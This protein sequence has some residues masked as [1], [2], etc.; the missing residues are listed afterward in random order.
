[1]KSCAS[2][3]SLATV[4][5]LAQSLI[6]NGE[7]ELISCASRLAASDC[8]LNWRRTRMI[9]LERDANEDRSAKCESHNRAAHSGRHELLFEITM[10]HD[11]LP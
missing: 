10:A 11:A 3:N 1:M 9:R 8:A 6:N 2:H 5:D 4:A 7:L